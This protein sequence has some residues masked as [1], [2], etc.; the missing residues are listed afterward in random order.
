M[1]FWVLID[2]LGRQ[3]LQSVHGLSL[4]RMEKDFA[5]KATNIIL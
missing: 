3:C 5:K 4:S 1:E 2:P